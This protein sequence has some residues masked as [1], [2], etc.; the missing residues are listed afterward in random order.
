MLYDILAFF[1]G[2]QAETAETWLSLR[3]RLLSARPTVA[4]A[5]AT[6]ADLAGQGGE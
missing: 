2:L 6:A 3:T 4:A 5:K 1:D